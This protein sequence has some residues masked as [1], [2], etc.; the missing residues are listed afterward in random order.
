MWQESTCCLGAPSKIT[1]AA[2]ERVHVLQML[3]D[4]ETIG[5]RMLVWGR[6]E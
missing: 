6:G 5:A 3:P 2:A 1:S 4:W